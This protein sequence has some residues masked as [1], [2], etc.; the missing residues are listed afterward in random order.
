MKE[1]QLYKGVSYDLD[2]IKNYKDIVKM[3]LPLEKK[4]TDKDDAL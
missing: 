2:N 1:T 4:D 3:A